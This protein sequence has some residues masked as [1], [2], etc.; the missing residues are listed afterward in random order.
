[1]SRPSEATESARKAKEAE[2]RV[3]EE[4]KLKEDAEATV[5][6]VRAAE[7]RERGLRED[8]EARERSLREE[9]DKLLALLAQHN[10]QPSL[11]K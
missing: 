3:Q 9:A 8:A 7:E 5:C 11:S 6:R 4:R 1:M 10:I 2:A